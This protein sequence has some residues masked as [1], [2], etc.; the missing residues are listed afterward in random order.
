MPWLFVIFKKK[1]VTENK[2]EAVQWFVVVIRYKLL[3]TGWFLALQLFIVF[4][5]NFFL[6]WNLDWG[7]RRNEKLPKSL[8]VSLLLVVLWHLFWLFPYTI[9]LQ[10]IDYQ[11]FHTHRTRFL[12]KGCIDHSFEDILLEIGNNTDL[13]GMWS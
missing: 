4:N 13:K 3:K 5:I 2:N 12:A 7:I 11:W 6:Q 1:E 9:T 8:F 10:S